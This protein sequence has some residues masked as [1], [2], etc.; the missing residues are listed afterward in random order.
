MLDDRRH[1]ADGGLEP[2]GGRAQDRGVP[3][4]G[5]DAVVVG[6]LVGHEQ[7]IGA[8]PLDVRVLERLPGSD[9]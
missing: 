6:V 5:L 1:F 2:A 4:D 7:Q 8:Q 3:A 9:A